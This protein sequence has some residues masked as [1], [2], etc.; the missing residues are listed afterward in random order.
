V[1]GNEHSSVPYLE[2]T[3]DQDEYE[4][5]QINV[6]CSLSISTLV[7]NLIVTTP[8]TE[9][10]FIPV[11]FFNN[12]FDV[13]DVA[14]VEKI[15]E[16][17]DVWGEGL[18]E[19]I[20]WLGGI[21]KLATA[22]CKTLFSLKQATTALGISISLIPDVASGVQGLRR[23]GDTADRSVDV[24]KNNFFY[25]FCQ[26]I[27]CRFANEGTKRDKGNWLSTFGGGSGFGQEVQSFLLKTPGADLIDQAG[28]DSAQYVDPRN[29][30]YLSAVTLCVPGILE[31]LAKYRQIQCFYGYCLQDIAV[32]AG[33]PSHACAETK[34][35]A[36]CKYFVTPLFTLFPIV[37]FFDDWA[38]KVKN[39]LRDP[40][41]AIG[42]VAELSCPVAEQT[43]WTLC[44]LTQIVSTATEAYY[45]ILN[46]VAAFEEFEN[47]YC[48]EL[49]SSSR[50]RKRS[51]SSGVRSR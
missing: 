8:E 24:A 12:P 48:D 21:V 46:V 38:G 43:T 32:D 16:I 20:K 28:G 2:L 25:E 1:V 42:L 5:N 47:D 7:G 18:G 41:V 31:N 33:I 3:F 6:T 44:R 14:V 19:I 39:V 29:N 45:D 37:N 10:V 11:Q 36:T 51:S 13:P 40:F 17:Q 22:M 30:L 27:N 15:D 50:R 9:E 26:F 35:Y 23:G 49:E 4:V 34:A